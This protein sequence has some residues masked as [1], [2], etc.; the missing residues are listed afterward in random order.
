VEP[1]YSVPQFKILLHLMFSFSYL[2]SVISVLNFLC[3]RF[4]IPQCS[5]LHIPKEMLNGVSTV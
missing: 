2:K 1:P 3:L 4:Y 5:N